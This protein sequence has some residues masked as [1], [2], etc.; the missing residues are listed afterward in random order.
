MD[1]DQLEHVFMR[2]DTSPT[3]IRRRL[4]AARLAV[5]MQQQEVAKAVG[6]SKQTYHYQEQRGAPSVKTGRYYYRAHGIDF[7]YLLNGD[8]QQLPGGI[9]ERLC[10]ELSK[11]SSD[12][13]HKEN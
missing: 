6:I 2:G 1:F 3:A 10:E 13:D 7:N 4:I 12:A 8:F 5:G 11:L 9:S